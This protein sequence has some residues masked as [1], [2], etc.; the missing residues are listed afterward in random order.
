M[1]R[2]VDLHQ[3]TFKVESAIENNLIVKIQE[4]KRSFFPPKSKKYCFFNKAARK[5]STTC[6]IS[7]FFEDLSFLNPRYHLK[8]SSSIYIQLVVA[9]DHTPSKGIIWE[10]KVFMKYFNRRCNFI[11]SRREVFCKKGV[12][13]S[14]AKFP[15]KHLCQSFSLQLYLK[16][17]S[18]TGVFR[19]ILRNC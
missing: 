19:R 11:S 15:G 2:F 6:K 9:K 12:L 14:F 5:T 16:R 13:R 8:I 1:G 3:C 7:N 10:R 4:K 17:N 18:D